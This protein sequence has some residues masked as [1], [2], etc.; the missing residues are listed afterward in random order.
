MIVIDP[1]L[2]GRKYYTVDPSTVY[3][4]RGVIVS[5]TTLLIGEYH[6]SASKCNRLATHKLTDCRF[7]V[8]TVP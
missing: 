2:L 6:D 1:S 7:I 5:G 4:C 8:P 3:A